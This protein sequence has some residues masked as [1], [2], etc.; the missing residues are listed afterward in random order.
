MAIKALLNESVERLFI[1]PPDY[2]ATG[3]VQRYEISQ[4][5]DVAVGLTDPGHFDCRGRPTCRKS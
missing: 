2:M 3:V 5:L 4:G 1:I